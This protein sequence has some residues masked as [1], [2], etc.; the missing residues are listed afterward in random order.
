MVQQADQPN[1]IIVSEGVQ[2]QLVVGDGL[3]YQQQYIIRHEPPPPPPPRPEFQQQPQQQQHQQQTLHRHQVSLVYCIVYVTILSIMVIT[4]YNY[5]IRMLTLV[6]T[7]T[8]FTVHKSK[9]NNVNSNFFLTLN[10]LYVFF[11]L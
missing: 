9:T 1:D 8:L 10:L 6:E 4:L 11:H 2:Q 5:R 3:Q 7:G